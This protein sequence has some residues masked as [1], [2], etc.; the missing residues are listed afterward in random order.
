VTAS[1]PVGCLI[2]HATGTSPVIVGVA[3]LAGLV[4]YDP[5][6]LHRRTDAERA[7]Q[8]LSWRRNDKSFFAAGACHILAWVFLSCEDRAAGFS[9]VGL[10]QVGEEYMNHVYV[11]DG[12]WAFDHDGWTRED[13]LLAVTRAARADATPGAVVER[14]ALLKDLEQFCAECNYRLP[15]QFAY[16]AVPRARAY[17]ARFPPHPPDT[18]R[19]SLE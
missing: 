9:P 12:R 15:S 19:R 14:L 5:P 16:D 8:L 4:A 3:W 10:R 17:I 7:D 13:E 2:G 1:A 11:S 18:Y 6:L